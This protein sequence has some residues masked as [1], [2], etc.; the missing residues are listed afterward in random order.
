MYKLYNTQKDFT[1]GLMS[2][3]KNAIPDV[4][5]FTAPTR[6]EREDLLF[7]CG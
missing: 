4:L 2:F 6:D 3:L 1:T 5:V 7:L